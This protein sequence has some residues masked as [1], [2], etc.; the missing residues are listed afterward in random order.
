MHFFTF[1]LALFSPDV[2]P[3]QFQESMEYICTPSELVPSTSESGI[4]LWCEQGI[5]SGGQEVAGSFWSLSFFSEHSS[6]KIPV[7]MY[8]T[9]RLCE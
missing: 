6:H 5:S 1:K 2:C 7:Q 3:G 9:V 4:S 8:R